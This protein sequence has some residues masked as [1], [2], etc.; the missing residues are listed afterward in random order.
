MMINILY[1]FS[2]IKDLTIN[3]ILIGFYITQD[4]HEIHPQKMQVKLTVDTLCSIL[5]FNIVTSSRT[6][7]P[8]WTMEIGFQILRHKNNLFVTSNKTAWL[9]FQNEKRTCVNWFFYL[10]IW[11]L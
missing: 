6:F 5:L 1:Y 8:C 2:V 7:K 9:Q 3:Y 10:A 4:N 11:I